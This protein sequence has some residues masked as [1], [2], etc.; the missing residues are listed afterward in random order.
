MINPILA[1]KKE[2]KENTTRYKLWATHISVKIKK[3]LGNIPSIEKIE[4]RIKTWESIEAKLKSTRYKYLHEISDIVGI[5]IVTKKEEDIGNILNLLFDKF[6]ILRT[7]SLIWDDNPNYQSY[8]AIISEI[9]KKQNFLDLQAEI[10]VKT[11]LAEA[12]S[13]LQ[14]ELKYSE[15]DSSS[16]KIKIALN[17]TYH[18]EKSLNEFNILLDKPGVHE[19]RD[20][21]P[22]L[23]KHTFILSPFAALILSE[24]QI[25]IGKQFQIDFLIR[26]PNGTYVLI[27]IENPRH[28]LFTKSGS[29]TSAASHAVGQIE[30]WQEWIED[31]LPSVQRKYPDISSPEGIL[32]IGRSASLTNDDRKKL[33]RKNINTRGRMTILTYDDLITDAKAYLKSINENLKSQ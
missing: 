7:T 11:R 18:L 27:E 28:K 19:K 26:R 5:R 3:I 6:I 4:F 10:Q 15:S 24:Q 16:T 22:F 21:H 12:W 13:I 8:H 33:K 1:A 25:G 29:L 17:K 31:N 32:I 9:S 30:D 14:H 2:Y 20:I 23:K